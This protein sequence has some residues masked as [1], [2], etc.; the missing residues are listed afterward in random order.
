MHMYLPKI[1]RI[2]KGVNVRAMKMP[3]LEIPS[4]TLLAIMQ[5]CSVTSTVL[6]ELIYQLCK[7]SA[8]TI[9]QAVVSIFHDWKCVQDTISVIAH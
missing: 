4:L 2:A 3:C 1:R 6:S 5:G 7:Y 9:I 8:D